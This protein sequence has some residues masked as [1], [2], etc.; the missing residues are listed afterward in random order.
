MIAYT[1]LLMAMAQKKNAKQIQQRFKEDYLP[2][3]KA[4][5]KIWPAAQF[6]NQSLVPLSFRTVSMDCVSFFWDM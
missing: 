5:L 3:V 1:F 6:L 2:T 4:G